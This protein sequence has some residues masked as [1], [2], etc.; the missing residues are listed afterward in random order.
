MGGPRSTGL[1]P[2]PAPKSGPD[3]CRG[4]IFCA[5]V[6]VRLQLLRGRSKLLKLLPD[7]LPHC[8]APHSVSH[9]PATRC[10]RSLVD[11]PR[12]AHS[13]TMAL[14]SRASRQALK[15]TAEGPKFSLPSFGKSGCVQRQRRSGHRQAAPGLPHTHKIGCRGLGWTAQRLAPQGLAHT[16][17]HKHHVPASSWIQI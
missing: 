5:W 7:A 10:A 2:E 14:A 13:N 15:V 4:E 9:R 3:G 17:L 6:R 12:L 8:C 16:V 11:L 1:N